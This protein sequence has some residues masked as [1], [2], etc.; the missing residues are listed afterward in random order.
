M[1]ANLKHKSYFVQPKVVLTEA[2]NNKP[3]TIDEIP[4]DK[5]SFENFVENYFKPEVPVVLKNVSARW[6]AKTKW[7]PAWLKKAL[8]ASTLTRANYDSNFKSDE[9]FLKEDYETPKLVEQC[10]ERSCARVKSRRFWVTPAGNVTPWHYDGHSVYVFNVQIFGT[11]EWSLISPTEPL[12]CYP[13]S[14]HVA[15]FGRRTIAAEDTYQVTTRADDM[16]FIPPLWFH[17]VA[18]IEESVNL[19]WIGTKRSPPVESQHSVREMEILKLV[20]ILHATGSKPLLRL[21]SYLGDLPAWSDYFPNY[22]GEGWKLIEDW[23]RDIPAH[24]ALSRA[25]KEMIG[26]KAFFPML[27]TGLDPVLKTSF[28]RERRA[29]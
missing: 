28:P 16:L 23:T 29:R 4:I 9:H 27:R 24:S 14:I 19:N 12:R 3:K 18:A 25:C 5:I 22:G 21:I 8:D 10:L 26:L 6:P 20:N 11:K 7:N 15:P 2:S 13:F 1:S 17:R